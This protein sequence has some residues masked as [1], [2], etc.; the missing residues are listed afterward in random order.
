MTLLADNLPVGIRATADGQWYQFV[1]TWQ[2]AEVV[3][4]A[5]KTG[6]V[7]DDVARYAAENPTPLEPAPAT[8]VSTP[9]G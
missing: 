2:G 4:G 1:V 5:T 8:T 6:G 3:I 9:A 7:N